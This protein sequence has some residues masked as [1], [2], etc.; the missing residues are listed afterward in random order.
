MN[1]STV[2]TRELAE[3]IG[4]T[5]QCV[6]NWCATGKVKATKDATGSYRIP[7]SE[8]KRMAGTKKAKRKQELREIK[9]RL[10]LV[11]EAALYL[12]ISQDSLRVLLRGRALPYLTSPVRVDERDLD[13]FIERSKIPAITSGRI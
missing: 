7:A 4:I 5:A 2:S 13:A 1:A 3:R 12:N 8:A 6:V 9:T 11:P 10:L